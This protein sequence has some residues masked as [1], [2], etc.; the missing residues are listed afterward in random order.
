MD[1]ADNLF[2]SVLVFKCFDKAASVFGHPDIVPEQFEMPL[3]SD[4]T[5]N[6]E[7][8]VTELKQCVTIC[9]VQFPVVVSDF[10]P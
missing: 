6:E 9:F 4:L 8:F 1:P 5:W 7:Q 2:R 3:V 10:L